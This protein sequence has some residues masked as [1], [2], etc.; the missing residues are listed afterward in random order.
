MRKFNLEKIT[1]CGRC[2]TPLP[3][4]Q[5]SYCPT[6]GVPFSQASPTN[7]YSLI[8]QKR[9]SK[10]LF[11]KHLLLFSSSSLIFLFAFLLISVAHV[12]KSTWLYSERVLAERNVV[13][14]VQQSPVF[15][16]LKEEVLHDAIS[17]SLLVLED[18]FHFRIKNWTLHFNEVPHQLKNKNIE[19][20]QS[21]EDWSAFDKKHFHATWKKN[22][23]QALPIFISNLPITIGA[24][25][26]IETGHL[27][28][29]KLLGG[30][31][32]PSFVLVSAYRLLKE[33]KITDE[34]K[35]KKY[36]AEYLI[37]HE[38]GHALLGIK[39]FVF[40]KDS[41][42]KGHQR[43][44]AAIDPLKECLMHTSAGGGHGSWQ[45]IQQR[46]VGKKSACRLY[47]RHFQ[48]LKALDKAASRYREGD[49]ETAQNLLS[50]SETMLQPTAMAWVKNRVQ[51]EKKLFQSPLRAWWNRL[52]MVE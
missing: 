21:Y 4:E 33:L 9:E 2:A 35:Q 30:L 44:L 17:Q 39:D 45:E 52:F 6:C 23:N 1:L 43:S 31:G 13:F 32:G 48:A 34:E 16:Q 3:F 25:A 18:H 40:S 29:S 26:N 8:A 49:Y 5:M 47:D 14:Y 22:P 27:S 36:L 7:D 28:E 20:M 11:K 24:H 38:L 37:A 50:Q 15:P 19:E 10:N 51:H 12:H 41:T 46:D 42:G